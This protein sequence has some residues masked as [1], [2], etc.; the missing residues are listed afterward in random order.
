MAAIAVHF[1]ALGQPWNAGA[2]VL[3]LLGSLLVSYTRARAEGLGA[4]CTVGFGTRLERVIILGV[5][6][7]AGLVGPAIYLL[8][9]LTGWTTLQRIFHTRQQLAAD[10]RRPAG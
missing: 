9:I 6:L 4:T 2:V 1:A 3:A 5:G 8:I 10:R 7:V